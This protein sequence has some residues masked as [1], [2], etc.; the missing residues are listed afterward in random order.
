MVESLRPLVSLVRFRLWPPFFKHLRDPSR[1][2]H[3]TTTGKSASH[4][5]EAWTKKRSLFRCR[6]SVF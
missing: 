4:L 2:P 1:G 3:P 5:D 6:R